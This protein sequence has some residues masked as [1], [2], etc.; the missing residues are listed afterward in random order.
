[1]TDKNS[2][3]GQISLDRL[4]I[5]DLFARYAHAVDLCDWEMLREVFS[6]DVEA[7]YTTV[8]QYTQNHAPI[9]HGI[10]DIIHYFNTVMPH[11]GPGLTHFMTNHLIKLDGDEA[12]ITSHNHV[13]NL[14]QGGVYHTHAKRT[15]KGW[16]LDRLRFEV[17]YFDQVAER[18]NAHMNSIDGR[19]V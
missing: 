19:S 15:P 16:R 1:M 13:L 17:R 10:D 6:D 14:A 18:M 11:I 5:L 7:N 12:N 4:D 2:A 3:S 8:A 9:L